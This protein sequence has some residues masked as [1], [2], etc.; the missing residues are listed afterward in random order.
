M[1]YQ[2]IPSVIQGVAKNPFPLKREVVLSKT[3]PSLY[4][5]KEKICFAAL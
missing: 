5:Y 4:I 3:V 2:L 1:I